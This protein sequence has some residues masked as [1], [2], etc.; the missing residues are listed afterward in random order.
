MEPDGSVKSNVDK[1]SLRCASFEKPSGAH[2]HSLRECLGD[3]IA[4]HVPADG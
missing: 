4:S 2:L 1:D 3:G